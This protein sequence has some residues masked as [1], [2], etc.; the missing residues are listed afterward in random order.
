MMGTALPQGTNLTEYAV[1]PVIGVMLM[2]TVTII[3]AATLSAFVG[4][5]TGELKQNPQATLTVTTEGSGDSFNIV[6]E[7]RGGD[8]LR[9]VD[10]EIITWVKNNDGKMIKHVQDPDADRASLDGITVRLPV[11]YKSQSAADASQEFGSAVWTTGTTAGTW[12]STGTAEFLGVSET[13]LDGLVA[14]RTPVEVDI[15]H[16]PS[17]I[18]IVK[19]DVLLG[20]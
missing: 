1:S 18:V 20:G 2:I 11:I 13:E 4:G 14:N 8:T 15:V 10:L 9:T 17:G 3:I 16:R 19:S 7:H 6:F 12:D 5:S